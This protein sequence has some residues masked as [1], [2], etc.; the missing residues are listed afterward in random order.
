MIPPCRSTRATEPQHAD[1][2]K[3]PA[4]GDRVEV[5]WEDDDVYFRGVLVRAVENAWFK[6]L[7]LYED[8]DSEVVE[9]NYEYWRYC[10]D[11]VD[12]LNTSFVPGDIT[13][14][15]PGTASVRLHEDSSFCSTVT[16]FD[17]AVATHEEQSVPGKKE[18]ECD[19]E[20]VSPTAV[21]RAPFRISET[22]KPIEMLPI[23]VRLKL[24]HRQRTIM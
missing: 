22:Q 24:E 3:P 10:G 2:A 18:S 9:L 15:W 6:F 4:V 23:K 13:E 19:P 20:P 8:G 17:K 7:I 21:H 11:D 12:N 1:S 5:L 14:L 16:Q